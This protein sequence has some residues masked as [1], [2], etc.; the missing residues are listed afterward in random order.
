MAARLVGASA[1]QRD[2][3]GPGPPPHLRD[4]RLRL[5][6]LEPREIARDVLLPRDPLVEE[7]PQQRG[8]RAE[9]LEP[10]IDTLLADAARP[11]SHDEDAMTVVGRRRGID[12][13]GHDHAGA[14][15][16]VSVTPPSTTSVW[17]VIQR[18]SSLAR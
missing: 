12:P 6:T 9:L 8:D 5:G 17:P 13:L 10:C 3:S 4:R 18:A 7:L 14:H 15:R 11:E 2:A 1:E 16:L